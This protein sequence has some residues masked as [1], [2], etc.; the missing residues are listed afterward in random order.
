MLTA[1]LAGGL[2]STVVGCGYTP[3]FRA[4]PGVRSIAVPIFDNETFPLR[5]EVEYDLTSALRKEIQT[6]TDLRLASEDDADM[7]VYGTVSRFRERVIAEGRV[8]EKIESS[9][10]VEVALRV[11]DYRNG[12][13]WKV[14]PVSVTEPLSVQTGE[15][16]DVARSRA[17]GNLAERILEELE[18][19]EQD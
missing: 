2:L 12:L 15:T 5:R 16:L 6:R 18:S 11:E 19:W 8:D 13:Q 10:V 4:P 3:G 17:I 7:V 1:L 14:G 9:I